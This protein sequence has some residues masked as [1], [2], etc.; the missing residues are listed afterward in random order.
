M[1]VNPFDASIRKGTK[2]LMAH[3]GYL[4]RAEGRGEMFAEYVAQTAPID[5]MTLVKCLR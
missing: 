2:L 3:N 1:A 5:G 4:V